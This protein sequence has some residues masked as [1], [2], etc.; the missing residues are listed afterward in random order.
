MTEEIEITCPHCSRPV[1]VTV[2]NK[3]CV[4]TEPGDETL[5]TTQATFYPVYVTEQEWKEGK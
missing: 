5:L 2:Y 1:K 4:T 3:D